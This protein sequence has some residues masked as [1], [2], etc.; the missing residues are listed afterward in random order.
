MVTGSPHSESLHSRGSKHSEQK[1]SL[2]EVQVLLPIELRVDCMLIGKEA[3]IQP[4]LWALNNYA[5]NFRD[6]HTVV[7]GVNIDYFVAVS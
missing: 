1:S 4:N 2:K 3:C 7:P 5:N 6:Q